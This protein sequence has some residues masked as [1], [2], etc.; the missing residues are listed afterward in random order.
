MNRELAVVLVSGGMDSCVT[1]A[2]AV[3]RGA[4]PALMHVQYGQRTMRRERRAFD[5]VADHYGVPGSR[6][7]VV[8]ISHLSAIGG[9]SLTDPSESVADGRLDA[10]G[11]PR[12]Y[13]PFRNGNLIAIAASW[14]EVLGAGSIWLGVVEEDGS[15]YPDCRSGFIRAMEQALRL[16][17][18]R[19]AGLRVETPLVEL[20]KAGIVRRGTELNAPFRLTWSC[21][22][23]EER[24][25]GT[26]DS[27][28]LRLRG[29]ARAG[30]AD[31]ILYM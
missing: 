25:C 19:G 27:C 11:V 13:V 18:A 12:T 15:G 6:R 28:L 23:E 22:R 5:A 14:A 21:Y 16:G 30:I 17:T 9:S 29:F 10:A 31:P 8:D 1:L 20:D 4:E 3:D 7:L 2:E 24:A 26:C